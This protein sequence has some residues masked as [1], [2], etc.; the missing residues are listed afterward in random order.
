MNTEKFHLGDVLS[1]TT[2]ILL[3][4]SGI[5]GPH[6]LVE[7]LAGGPVWTHQIGR[8]AEES[9]PHLL[10][11]FP[12]TEHITGEG[13]TPENYAEVMEVLV[14]KHGE[15]LDVEPMPEGVHEVIDPVSELAEIIHPEKIIVVSAPQRTN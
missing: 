12:W 9:L 2:G 4:P 1:L 6:K 11:Q 8:V 5:S 13:I 3:S 10:K 15:W 14:L 7:Y